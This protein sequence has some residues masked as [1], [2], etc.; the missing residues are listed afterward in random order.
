MRRSRCI[1][2]I[3]VSMAYQAVQQESPNYLCLRVNSHS[4]NNVQ[5]I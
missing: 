4:L 5:I 3:G 1:K 2:L